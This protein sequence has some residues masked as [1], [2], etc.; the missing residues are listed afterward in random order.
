MP[1]TTA[2]RKLLRT[3]WSP[4]Q[5]KLCNDSL[6]TDIS[7]CSGLA[8]HEGRLDLRGLS[9]T[10][11]VVY[12]QYSAIDFS[13]CV[14]DGFGQFN[15]STFSDCLFLLAEISNNLTSA[16][17]HCSFELAKFSEV[18]VG[19]AFSACDFLG[20]R[21]ARVLAVGATFTGCSFRGVRIGRARL[22]RCTFDSCDFT[23]AEFRRS[24][25]ER[26]RFINS[27]IA[28]EQLTDSYLEDVEFVT[29]TT[30]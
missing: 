19:E 27:T 1:Y 4:G 30:E 9:I 17:D 22:V 6:G 8:V 16:F 11:N 26:T 3:R 10:G 2:E 12:R 5:L 18:K 14:F 29:A 20:S 21:W 15:F 23:G 7:K 13:C 24:E 25:L 28:R